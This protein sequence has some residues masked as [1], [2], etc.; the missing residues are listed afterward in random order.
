M[1]GQ[2]VEMRICICLYDKFPYTG[3]FI[4]SS[5]MRTEKEKTSVEDGILTHGFTN[6]F[7]LDA[8]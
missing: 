1:N 3:Q 8:S 2:V 6:A 4:G 7:V 5:G